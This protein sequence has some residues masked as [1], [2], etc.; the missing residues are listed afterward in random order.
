MLGRNMDRKFL[1]SQIGLFTDRGAPF[2]TVPTPTPMHPRADF[3][4][5]PNIVGSDPW[6]KAT[7]CEPLQAQ[8]PW[9]T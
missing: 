9:V 7:S 5:R 1:D 2:L 3:L 8:N 6:A 4:P